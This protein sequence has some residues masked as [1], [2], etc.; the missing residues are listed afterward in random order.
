M[1]SDTAHHEQTRDRLLHAA[2]DEFARNGFERASVRSICDAAEAN[3]S[4]VKYHFG[5]KHEL[6]LA[7]WDVAATQMVSAE[8]M[9]RP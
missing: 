1:M 4:A 8:P 7:V 3:V 9:P 6:Y 2:G 5:S